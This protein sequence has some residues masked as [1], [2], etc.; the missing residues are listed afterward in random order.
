MNKT[1]V[2]MVDIAQAFLMQAQA[3]VD[4]VKCDGESC[5]GADL[6]TRCTK[7][8]ESGEAIFDE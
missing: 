3:K 2:T 5:F 7:Q 1:D 8:N 4:I 6:C